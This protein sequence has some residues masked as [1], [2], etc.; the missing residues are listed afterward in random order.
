MIKA[1]ISYNILLNFSETNNNSTDFHSIH[2]F[3]FFAPLKPFSKAAGA[4]KYPQQKSATDLLS[5]LKKVASF[6][7]CGSHKHVIS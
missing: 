2:L 1:I 3:P 6:V 5:H 4:H 7:T